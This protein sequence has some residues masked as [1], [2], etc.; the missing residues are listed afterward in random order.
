[1]SNSNSFTKLVS[2]YMGH[3]K[4]F[5][6]FIERDT[7][8]L[9][10]FLD[11]LLPNTISYVPEDIETKALEDANELTINLN[12]DLLTIKKKFI[13]SVQAYIF[14]R[15]RNQTFKMDTDNLNEIDARI[16]F[17]ES[18]NVFQDKPPS[19]N[20][21]GGNQAG[22]GNGNGNNSSRANAVAKAKERTTL[23]LGGM[24]VSPGSSPS[25]SK[26]INNHIIYLK[27]LGINNRLSNLTN[28]MHEA[29]QE[30]KNEREAPGNGNGNPPAAN[31]GN[32]N[33]NGNKKRTG[34]GAGNAKVN[35]AGNQTQ[36]NGA[37]GAGAGAGNAKVNGNPPAANRGR[38]WTNGLGA[39]RNYLKKRSENSQAAKNVRNKAYNNLKN[40]INNSTP[41]SIEY[42]EV[43]EVLNSI[44]RDP[45]FAARRNV[46]MNRLQEKQ[47]RLFG[48]LPDLRGNRNLTLGEKASKMIRGLVSRKGQGATAA[49][50][51][52][53]GKSRLRGVMNSGVKGLRNVISAGS[54]MFPNKYSKEYSS[55]L[56][57]I[58][59]G[60][61]ST[62]I[63]QNIDKFL[64]NS[65]N[66][67][68][69]KKWK[70]ALRI[71]LITSGE[72][73]RKV[74]VQRFLKKNENGY[75]NTINDLEKFIGK[76]KN[77]SRPLNATNENEKNKLLDKLG[78]LGLTINATSLKSIYKKKANANR[79]T[80]SKKFAK[81]R[82]D[83]IKRRQN[84]EN[85]DTNM[86]RIG[87]E[88]PLSA[89]NKTRILKLIENLKKN[90]RTNKSSE[91][92]HKYYRKI[93]SDSITR[94]APPV[95]PTTNPAA[96]AATNTQSAKKA[97]V[98]EIQRPA[99]HSEGLPALKLRGNPQST[100]PSSS[101]N[102][103]TQEL[104]AL[105][106]G[107]DL[108]FPNKITTHIKN[109]KNSKLNSS[110]LENALRKRKNRNNPFNFKNLPP[111]GKA[112]IPQNGKK[113][114]QQLKNL[115]EARNELA[116]TA[117]TAKVIEMFGQ[118]SRNGNTRGVFKPASNPRAKLG[119]RMNTIQEGNENA[120]R[121]AANAR[122]SVFANAAAKGKARMNA[123]ARQAANQAVKNARA[124]NAETAR[125]KKAENA[126]NANVNNTVKEELNKK[127]N[128]RRVAATKIQAVARGRS[129]RIAMKKDRQAAENARAETARAKKAAENAQRAKNAEEAAKSQKAA[130]TARAAIKIQAAV[131]GKRNRKLVA[132]MKASKN[133]AVYNQSIVPKKSNA[134]REEFRKTEKTADPLPL[135][136]EARAK[137]DHTYNGYI[138]R[139]ENPRNLIG[140]KNEAEILRFITHLRNTRRSNIANKLS[141]AWTK[142]F[143]P[144]P[145]QS[146]E[147]QGKQYRQYI[148]YMHLFERKA[149]INK[150]ELT[151]FINQLRPHNANKANKLYMKL[152]QML[153][154]PI[155]HK[156]TEVPRLRTPPHGQNTKRPPSTKK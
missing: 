57:K 109:L 47:P 43:S 91:L 36:K 51:N 64:K 103:K 85:F 48:S 60:M 19:T 115:K 77:N 1:M 68:E 141:S 2:L 31:R 134:A 108:Y 81:N 153:N 15:L 92:E 39:A 150:E 58:K 125:T 6:L 96:K 147:N 142:K 65:E 27:S 53:N 95:T 118:G 128:A 76:L 56:S 82:I 23:L 156:G 78:K 100:Q 37:G 117:K 44:K 112:V 144:T 54:K 38:K 122:K 126:A 135:L 66:H 113:Q 18:I 33:G 104:I 3:R 22:K 80:F 94:R 61:N 145:T 16:P 59:P 12:S 8:N 97:R 63:L 14:W 114:L 123:R 4:N 73:T 130:E 111:V 24:V 149:A 49:T 146:P 98:A 133:A 137:Q 93:G 155:I 110:A 25:L 88:S 90:G 120:E 131:R 83:A 127:P 42:R 106:E 67:P 11:T 86:R 9:L 148:R 136:R 34:N 32:G 62:T 119:T 116:K 10:I 138:K 69:F 154:P 29:Q 13:L 143:K 35:G 50:G 121:A 101:L 52:G 84:D 132:S 74:N 30:E 26:Q 152:T 151:K 46:I 139:L 5:P 107:T 140:P 124:K 55:L 21:T 75:Q 79:N 17:L 41:N 102:A 87:M 129:V 89:N 105:L 20:G 7:R 28:R 71:A 70:E 99:Q 40:K 72:S 45:N